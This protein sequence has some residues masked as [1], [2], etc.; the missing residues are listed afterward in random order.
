MAISLMLAVFKLK[1]EEYYLLFCFCIEWHIFYI[2]S[3]YRDYREPWRVKISFMTINDWYHLFLFDIHKRS[4]IWFSKII[5]S[6]QYRFSSC[7]V[8]S[9]LIHLLLMAT[10][11][12]RA[13]FK[14]KIEEYYILFCF[15]IEWHIFYIFSDYRN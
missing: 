9:H 2:F 3:D 13:V 11:L 8:L 4:V 6:C 5:S 14:L 12:I 10:S 15:C 7:S 1:I